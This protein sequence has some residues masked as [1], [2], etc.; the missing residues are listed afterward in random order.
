MRGGDVSVGAGSSTPPKRKT[1]ARVRDRPRRASQ[2][3][4]RVVRHH[5]ACAPEPGAPFRGQRLLD[6]VLRGPA[7]I[8]RRSAGAFA[9]LLHLHAR[10][11]GGWRPSWPVR[12][13]TCLSA[14]SSPVPLACRPR[15]PGLRS[16]ARAAGG[17]LDGL[18]RECERKPRLLCFGERVTG[19][20]CSAA[21]GQCPETARRAS[22]WCRL[23]R[24]AG[25]ARAVRCCGAET[26]N[27]RGR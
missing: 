22:F 5:R 19:R 16:L 24:S 11:R 27:Q 1:R 10:R 26:A 21:R 13:R 18:V 20:S 14:A 23:G 8:V 7:A 2:P 4:S 17:A 25:R 6:C 15:A 9:S 12:T 3:D